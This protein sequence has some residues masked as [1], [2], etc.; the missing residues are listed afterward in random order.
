MDDERV[1]EDESSRGEDETPP[2][3]DLAGRRRRG[4]ETAGG[5][6]RRVRRRLD[7]SQRGLAEILGVEASRVA[8]WETGRTP[9]GV[10]E[11]EAVLALVG[12]RLVAVDAEGEVVDP[13]S[14][15][16]IRDRAGRRYPAHADLRTAGWWIPPGSW[17]TARAGAD[18]RRSAALG[19]PQVYYDLGWQRDAVRHFY[20]APDDHLTLARIVARL[21]TLDAERRRA[22]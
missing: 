17:L 4:S 11:L 20:G 6:V 15:E 5:L 16:A 8:R 12:L 18:E 14:E 1:G 7:V 22:S 13:M 21:R 19:D 9:P 3:T 10:G 2:T